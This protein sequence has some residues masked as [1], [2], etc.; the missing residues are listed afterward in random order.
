MNIIIENFVEKYDWKETKK[1]RR[2][3]CFE[4]HLLSSPTPSPPAIV[5][6]C[7]DIAKLNQSVRI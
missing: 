2:K 7:T 3:K 4:R 1:K 5:S 6:C